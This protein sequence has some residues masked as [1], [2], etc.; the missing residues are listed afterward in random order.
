MLTKAQV[1]RFVRD[2]VKEMRG[3]VQSHNEWVDRAF[4]EVDSWWGGAIG[5][6]RIDQLPNVPETERNI[7]ELADAVT[8][9]QTAQEEDWGI[10]TDSG[11]WEGLAP[12]PALVAQAFHTLQGAINQQ[13]PVDL[14]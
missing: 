7:K 10:E 4:E 14:R 13:E 3:E 1:K 8:I 2:T 12:F 6:G 11:L 9:L 5:T